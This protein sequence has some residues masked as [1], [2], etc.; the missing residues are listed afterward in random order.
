MIHLPEKFTQTIRNVH[1]AKGECWLNNFNKLIQYCEQKWSI[2]ILDPFP[3]SYN[4]VAPAFLKDGQ[5]VVLKLC[6]P[7]K[8]AITEI[9]TLRFYNGKGMVRLIEADTEKGIL[10]VER[11]RPGK[12]LNSLSNDQEA[13]LIAANLIKKMLARVSN[14]APVLIPSTVEWAQGFRKLKSHFNGKS[15]PLPEQMVYKAEAFFTKLNSTIKNPRLLHG[16]LHH[17]NILSSEKEWVAIDPKG[18]LGETEY[19]VVSFLMNHLPEKATLE[20][21]KS[22]INL[23]AKELSLQKERIIAWAFSQAVLSAW[24]CIEDGCDCVDDFMEKA[25]LFERLLNCRSYNGML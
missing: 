3:L 24:W 11:L 6:V 23:F 21:I 8:E 17:E 25:Y 5:K 7:N 2:H 22:R 14:H 18:V 16:D 15:G 9:E 12:T 19:E 1:Q 20:T 13:V 10:I 4:F